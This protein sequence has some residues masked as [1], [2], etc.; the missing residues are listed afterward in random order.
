LEIGLKERHIKQRYCYEDLKYKLNNV[1]SSYH[2]FL[3]ITPSSTA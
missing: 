1:D 2:C 3:H